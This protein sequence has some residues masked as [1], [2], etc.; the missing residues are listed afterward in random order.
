MI[1][2]KSVLSEVQAS[3]GGVEALRGKLQRS[4]LGSFAQGA[5][6]ADFVRAQR[7]SGRR[8]RGVLW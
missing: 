6:I 5:T 3:W 2:D 7:V 1:S 8:S 4:F